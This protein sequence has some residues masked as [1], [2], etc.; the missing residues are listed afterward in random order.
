[1]AIEKLLR[2]FKCQRFA[3][4]EQLA[5]KKI[6]S[7]IAQQG[8]GEFVKRR[9]NNRRLDKFFNWREM[10]VNLNFR[11]AKVT[12]SKVLTYY[13]VL[14]A[15]NVQGNPDL[16]AAATYSCLIDAGIGVGGLRSESCR[17]TGCG[18]SKPTPPSPILSSMPAGSAFVCQAPTAPP[19]SGAPWSRMNGAGSIGLPFLITVKCRWTPVA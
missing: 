12:F 4:A 3:F 2:F 14:P 8:F 17:C 15:S 7:P 13:F 19:S 6:A 10:C 16:R 5:E 9:R 18:R 1:M 11:R